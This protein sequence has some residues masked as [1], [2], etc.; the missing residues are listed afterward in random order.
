MRRMSE[1]GTAASASLVD[2]YLEHVD[3]Q[4]HPDLQERRGDIA[5]DDDWPQ[6]L[7]G[8]RHGDEPAQEDAADEVKEYLYDVDGRVEQGG[9][10]EH[11]CAM[12]RQTDRQVG[13]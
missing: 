13:R 8:P 10:V 6:R 5:A 7:V 2:S 12:D 4:N 3:A 9:S 11:G 1:R